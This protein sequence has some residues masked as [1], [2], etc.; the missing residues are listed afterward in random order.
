MNMRNTLRG[1]HCAVSFPN[2]RLSPPL[3][4]LREKD[5]APAGAEAPMFT[6]VLIRHD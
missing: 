5:G 1:A 6:G 4:A 3:S 2:F